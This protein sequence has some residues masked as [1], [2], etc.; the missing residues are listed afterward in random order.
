MDSNLRY[1]DYAA[2]VHPLADFLNKQLPM[3]IQ[4][5]RQNKSAKIHEKDMQ[6]MRL[7]GQKEVAQLNNDLSEKFPIFKKYVI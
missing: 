2:P 4:Q 1:R 7:D 6:Q 5:H 3:M